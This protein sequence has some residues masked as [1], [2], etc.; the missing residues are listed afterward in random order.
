SPEYVLQTVGTVVAA[1]ARGPQ[2]TGGFFHRHGRTGPLHAH[3]FAPRDLGQAP[4]PTGQDDANAQ[5]RWSASFWLHADHPL[6]LLSVVSEIEESQ[7]NSWWKPIE[8]E[9]GIDTIP[10]CSGQPA[11]RI[12]SFAPTRGPPCRGA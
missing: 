1:V 8:P 10:C 9:A 11:G 6:T 12:L 2:A 7:T 3:Q 4:R 5:D